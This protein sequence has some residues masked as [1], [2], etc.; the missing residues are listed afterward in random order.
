MNL[1][2]LRYGTGTRAGI[3]AAGFALALGMALSA[4]AQQAPSRIQV[5]A[6]S[7]AQGA[8]TQ[9]TFS[10]HVSDATGAPATDGEV[11]IETKQGSLGSAF[12]HDG[13]ATLTVDHLPQGTQE[14]TAVY[15]GSEHLSTSAAS[16]HSAVADA[17]SALPDFSVT[18]N[19]TSLSLTPGQYGTVTLTITPEN[20]FTNMVTLSCSGNPSGSTCVF[21]P[22]TLSP[23]NGTPVTSALQIQTQAGSGTAAENRAPHT[24]ESS[25]IAFAFILPGALALAGLGALRKR[26]GLASLRVLGLLALLTA[27]GLGLSA[28]AARYDYLHHPPSANP[29]VAA[30]TYTVTVAA[31]STNGTSVTSHSL[32]VALTIK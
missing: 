15:T 13:V 27:S 24:G 6:A 14:V 5:S 29:G 32:N 20:G 26:S 12:V 9:T 30:G 19:P 21:T 16:V 18:A 1:Q 25:H 3:R 10:A 22:A 4:S 28:C 23:L 11:S 8:G 31:Y 17:S 2:L 7:E